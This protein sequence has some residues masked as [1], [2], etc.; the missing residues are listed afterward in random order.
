MNKYYKRW[1]I[2]CKKVGNDNILTYNVWGYLTKEDVIEYLGLD[3]EDIE[4]YK[5]EDLDAIKEK[6]GQRMIDSLL[7]ALQIVFVLVLIACFAL[8]FFLIGYRY[9]YY[10]GRLSIQPR[11]EELINNQKEIDSLFRQIDLKYDSIG[12][13][14]KEDEEWAEK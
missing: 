11:V 14:M 6:G 2:T 4:W 8:F 7:K 12:K 9:G 10:N 13:L 5:I 1:K 3:E